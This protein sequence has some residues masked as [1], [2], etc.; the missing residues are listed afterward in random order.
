MD[1]KMA[2]QSASMSVEEG[3]ITGDLHEVTPVKNSRQDVRYFDATTMQTGQGDYG[4]VLC[5]SPEKGAA[6]QRATVNKQSVK[7]IDAQKTT[8]SSN[9]GTFDVLVSS[10]SSAEATEQ[11]PFPWR[12]LRTT[13]KVLIVDVLAL[14]PRQ[15][16]GAIEARLLLATANRMVPLNGVQSELRVFE[17]CDPTGQT[18]LTLWDRQILSVQERKSYRFTAL[19]TRKEGDRTMLRRRSPLWVM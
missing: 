7:S 14:G 19:S 10:R 1:Y 9:P 6:F 12:E 15:R 5:F 2:R 4:R 11:L 18:A 8:S 3:P 13:E 17:I 16:V